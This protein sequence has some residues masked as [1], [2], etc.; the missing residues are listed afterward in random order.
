MKSTSMS[1]RYY[2]DFCLI[3]S[4]FGLL[5]LFVCRSFS[6]T[7]R[8]N[9]QAFDGFV[10]YFGSRGYFASRIEK[11]FSE[12]LFL[13]IFSFCLLFLVWDWGSLS[14]EFEIRNGFFFLVYWCLEIWFLRLL[15]CSWKLDFSPWFLSCWG[16]NVYGV[17]IL[18]KRYFFFIL[19]SN[20]FLLGCHG[21]VIIFLRSRAF[22]FV[23]SVLFLEFWVFK[24]IWRTSR[25]GDFLLIFGVELML[26]VGK[27]EQ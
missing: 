10:T 17:L 19:I 16:T 23:D 8:S 2:L 14:W 21:F 26:L 5:L 13:F 4:Y 18:N 27:V 20:S 24:R 3:C 1:P 22:C 15:F 11:L 7:M 9:M 6:M 25:Q 12:L